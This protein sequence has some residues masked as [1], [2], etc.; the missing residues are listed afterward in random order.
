MTY[1]SALQYTLSVTTPVFLVVFLGIALKA[2]GKISEDFISVASGL[3]FNVCLPILIFISIQ[4]HAIDWIGQSKLIVFSMLTAVILFFG[5]WWFSRLYVPHEDRGVVVQGAFRSNL[6]II[7]LALCAKAYE[8][9]GLALG[10]VL[11][12]VVTPIYN[13]L[14]V[15]ALNRS[16]ESGRSLPVSKTLMDIAKN[17]LIIAIILGVVCNQMDLKLPKVMYDAGSYLAQMTLPLALIAIGGSLSLKELKAS[18]G[19]SLQVT[20]AKLILVPVSALVAAFHLGF[21]GA[22]LGCI[23]LMFASPTATASFIMVKAM[24]GNYALASNIIVLTTL[25][26]GVTISL[27]LYLS[28]MLGWLN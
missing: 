11:L 2:R 20:F 12:A 15:Y 21:R 17:P 6:G 25:L 5:F 27:L 4:D 19:L 24:G 13:I 8:S 28:V 7:G 23:L 3:V 26:S 18:T 1:L 16:L 22:E 14:S 10:A 9:N